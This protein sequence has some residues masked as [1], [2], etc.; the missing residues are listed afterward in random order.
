MKTF[1]IDLDRCNGCYACQLACKDEMVGNEWP[2]YSKPQPQTGQFWLKMFEKVHGQVP[3]VR[4]EYRPEMC[5]HCDEAPCIAAAPE[6]VYKRDD[7][8]VIVDPEKAKG[9]R[10]LV[11]ACPYG[12]IYFNEELDLAQKCTGCAHLVDAG[13]LPHCVDACATGALRFGEEEEFADEL[14]GESADVREPFAV[15][16][17]KPRVHYLHPFGLF[18]SGEVWDPAA[19]LIIEGAE[20]KLVSDDGEVRLTATDGFGDFWFRHLKAGNYELHIEAEG[21]EP[22]TREIDLAESLNIGDFPLEKK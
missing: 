1:V 19:D 12:A 8:L 4:V 18:V 9:A 20:V 16:G 3:K 22:V 7:G 2:P 10:G 5:R 15:A 17:T 13:K 11:D 14:A 6:A 21:F